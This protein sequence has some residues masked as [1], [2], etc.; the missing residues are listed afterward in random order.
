[1]ADTCL[2][3]E[4]MRETEDAAKWAVDI[5]RKIHMYPELGNEEYR[6]AS[7]VEA[8]LAEIGLESRRPLATS[9][10]AEQ[11]AEMRTA[12]EAC[13]CERK[14]RIVLRSELDA[15]DINEETGLHHT[16]CRAGYM[17]ACGHDAHIAVTL[18]TAR[19][20]AKIKNKIN[21]D[22]KYIFQQDEEGNGKGREMVALGETREDDIVLGLHVRPSIPSGSIGIKRGIISGASLMFDI[23]IGGK[24]SHGAMPH[25]GRDA[26]AAASA[27]VYTVYASV[28][29]RID[30]VRAYVVSF[31]SIKGGSRRNVIADSAELSGIIRAETKEMCSFIGAEIEKA[32][33]NIAEVYGCRAHVDFTDGY[34]PLINDSGVTE[35]LRAAVTEYN[36]VC[37]DTINIQE[38]DDFSLTVDDFA[39][40]LEKSKGTYFYLGSGFPDRENSDIHTSTF[41]IDESCIKV[42][43]CVLTA[44]ILKF[45]T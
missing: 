11:K 13:N 6:T 40:Y 22:V 32:A 34:P 36:S 7:L 4:V 24:K 35:T 38:M 21:T 27:I 39:Y 2:P 31:G 16:S 12:N 8:C 18:G 42:G 33:K 1:M 26:V 37:T 5:Y 20:L 45:N 19:V 17:H 29:R 44:A 3:A 28:G 30:P 10:T 23:R 15:I 14:K 43:I 25:L 9:V 41:C